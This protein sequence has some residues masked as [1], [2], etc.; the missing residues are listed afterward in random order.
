MQV[1]KFCLFVR[2]CSL[3]VVVVIVFFFFFFEEIF[4]TLLYKLFSFISIG[5]VFNF[6]NNVYFF[7]LHIILNIKFIIWYNLLGIFEK[8]AVP[9]Y[10]SILV[11]KTQPI[12]RSYLYDTKNYKYDNLF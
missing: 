2:S 1:V 6:R 3:F 4:F 9:Y 5:E 8:Y 10:V 11:N 12:V 7:F